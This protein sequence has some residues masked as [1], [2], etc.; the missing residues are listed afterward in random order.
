MSGGALGYELRMRLVGDD[1]RGRGRLSAS[2][3]LPRPRL[4]DGILRGGSGSN[5]DGVV[6]RV[7]TGV[8]TGASGPHCR[9]DDGPA[10]FSSRATYSSSASSS[11]AGAVAAGRANCGWFGGPN[12][13][14]GG[15]TEP[16]TV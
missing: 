5:N 6:G 7:E 8:K 9:V 15:D 11:H 1:G 3:T 14:R 2:K 12:A 16:A 13:S 10:P 4:R